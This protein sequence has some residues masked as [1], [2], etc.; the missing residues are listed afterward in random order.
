MNTNGNS[1]CIDEVF[2]CDGWKDCEDG[3]DEEDC[4]NQ[5]DPNYFKCE[6]G[7]HVHST[8]RCIM[9]SKVCDKIK[10][11]VDNSDEKNCTYS[12]PKDYLDCKMGHLYSRFKALPLKPFCYP[13]DMKCNG[14]RYK[15]TN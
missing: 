9:R 1:P 14:S 7:Y 8:S 13:L 2:K 4:S 12:C 11:C 15:K 10:D 5:C 6:R 3:S